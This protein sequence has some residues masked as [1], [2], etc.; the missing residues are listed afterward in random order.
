MSTFHLTVHGK[1]QGVSFR[2][3]AKKV[4][5]QLG[6]FGWVRNTRE[7]HVEMIVQGDKAD[8]RKFM[9][10]CGQGPAG[11]RVEHVFSEEINSVEFT[12]FKIEH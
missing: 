2:A 12:E 10:W 7:G 8:I 1:V 11:S 6:L 5:L 4:A 3:S 9:D